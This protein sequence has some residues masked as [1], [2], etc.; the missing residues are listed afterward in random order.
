MEKRINILD[1]T[2]RDGGYYNNWDFDLSLGRKYLKLMNDIGVRFVEIGFRTLD[3]NSSKGIF[4]HSQIEILNKLKIPNKINI[5]VMVNAS[6]FINSKEE[7]IKICKKYFTKNYLRKIKFIRFACHHDEIYK[8]KK[9]FDWFCKKGLIVFVNIMQISEIKF[10]KI[11]EIC[12]YLAKLNIQGIYLADSLGSLMPKQSKKIF[13]LFKKNWSK[14]LGLHAH[15]NLSL[16][17]K[18]SELAID[19][20]FQ[21]I[22]CTVMGMGRGPGNTLTEEIYKKWIRVKYFNKLLSNFIQKDFNKLKKKYKWGT[23]KFYRFAAKNKIHPS[24]IQKMLSDKRYLKKDYGK[25]LMILKKQETRKFNPLKIITEKNTYNLNPNGKWKPRSDLRNRKILILGSGSLIK[26]KKDEIVK[27][28]KKNKTLVIVLNTNQFLPESKIDYRVV[29]HPNRIISDSFFYKNNQSNLITPF[30]MMDKNLRK[31]LF[32]NNKKIF[33]FGLK[34]TSNKNLLIRENY[35]QF[36]IPL[37]I[38]YSISVC[39]SGKANKIFLA[40]FDGYKQNDPAKD[41]SFI[42]FKNLNKKIK[43]RISF[44]TKSTYV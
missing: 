38:V 41:E 8:L 20:G 36:N 19:N 9:V 44:L 6:E 1:C 27:F 18:N 23:N 12:N 43:N 3:T 21:W 4:A 32:S 22:D 25:M 40:G 10:E 34:I 15:N 11:K 16:A 37:A 39:I 28:I 13:Y 7:N 31:L 33:D 42:F 29:C 30:S 5:G 24:Y 2:F 17:L 26:K 35:C 14:D